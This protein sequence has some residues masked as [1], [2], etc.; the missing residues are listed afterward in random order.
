MRQM[1]SRDDGRRERRREVGKIGESWVSVGASGG[2]SAGVGSLVV[3][4]LVEY[5]GVRCYT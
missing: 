4:G 1:R 3:M 5:G 2:D